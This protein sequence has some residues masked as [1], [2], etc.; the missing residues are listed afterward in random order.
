MNH[1]ECRSA[2]HGGCRMSRRAAIDQRPLA[3]GRHSQSAGTACVR[4]QFAKANAAVRSTE[5]LE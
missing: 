4:P 1:G 3:F 2:Q 5:L